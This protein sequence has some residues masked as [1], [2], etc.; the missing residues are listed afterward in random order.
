MVPFMLLTAAMTYLWPNVHGLGGAMTV[1]IIYGCVLSQ[2]SRW[3]KMVL[4]EV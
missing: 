1:A 2:S 4:T 3:R